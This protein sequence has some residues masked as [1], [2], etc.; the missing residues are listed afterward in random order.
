MNKQKILNNIHDLFFRFVNCYMIYSVYQCQVVNDKLDNVITLCRKIA[1]DLKTSKLELWREI[2]KLK[3]S[4]RVISGS[5][6]D[7]D[8]EEGNRKKRVRLAGY[9]LQTKPGSDV[10]AIIPSSG[11]SLYTPL[12]VQQPAY[13]SEIYLIVRHSLT[14][15]DGQN[16]VFTKP[17]SHLPALTSSPGSSLYTPLPVQQPAYQFVRHSR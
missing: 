8:D 13:Q 11:S 10:P 4:R 16:I 17:G 3:A 6:T 7:L 5:D 1:D 2:R 14:L 15:G 9:D 12:P